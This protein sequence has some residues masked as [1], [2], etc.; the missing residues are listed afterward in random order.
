MLLIWEQVERRGG[1]GGGGGGGGDK[2]EEN[3][4]TLSAMC[5]LFLGTRV[6]R[7]LE[8]FF[9]EF[10]FTWENVKTPSAMCGLLFFFFGV[11]R[12]LEGF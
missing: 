8:V 3:V 12:L 7:F 5:G 2:V 4:E 9:P 6:R 1:G 10:F 11:R